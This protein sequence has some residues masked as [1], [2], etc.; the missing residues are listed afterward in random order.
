MISLGI[1]IGGTGCKCVAFTDKGQ[2]LASAYREYPTRLGEVNLNAILLRDCVFAVI[3]AC[4]SKLER[5]ADVTAIT[6]SSFG[7]SFVALDQ[8]GEPLQDIILY[9]ANAENHDFDALVEQVGAERFMQLTCA[10]PDASYS[11]AKMLHTQKTAPAPVWKYLFVASYLCYCL[12]GATVADYSLACRSI[13]FDVRKLTWSQEIL[14]ASKI[15]EEQ[16]PEVVP[17]GTAVGT[18]LPAVAAALG[19]RQE[20]QVVIGTHDQLV[21]ALGAGVHQCGEGVDITGTVECIEPLFDAIPDTL[22][23]QRQNYA[24]VPYFQQSGYVTYAYNVSGGAVVKWYRDSLAQ[25]LRAEAEQR[26]C[27][28]YDLLNEQCPREPGELLVLPQLQGMGG[29]PDVWPDARGMMY[30]LS[31]QTTLPQIYRAILEGL[32]FEMAHNLQ[33]LKRYGVA[34]TTLY[35][36]GG[37]ARSQ[38]WLQIKADILGCPIIPSLTEETGALGSAILGL[39]A[40][41]GERDVF[42]LAKQFVRH[43]EPVMPNRAHADIYA[44]KFE[45]YQKLRA[46]L[47]DHWKKNR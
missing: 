45:Q 12:S 32:T 39:A 10:L 4:T 17:S 28:I 44:E 5:A 33:C 8:A 7:E 18:L 35:A 29:T 23:F 40:V 43:G 9:F 16:L 31:M 30:G 34:P 47:V 25:H 20:V 15:S 19:L 26:G 37:G 1:D 36:C 6:V 13:L 21:N 42:R 38:V 3:Q 22:D 11:L 14:A 27:S 2:Q 24:C 46:F 41:T